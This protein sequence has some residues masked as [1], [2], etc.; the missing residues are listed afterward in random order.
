MIKSTRFAFVCAF[1]SFLLLFVSCPNTV[2]VHEE[3]Q[4]SQNQ[5]GTLVVT[6]G[7]SAARALNVSEI[8]KA[9]VSVS[10]TGITSPLLKT[11]VAISA[12]TAGEIKIEN[13]PV[14]KNRVVTVEAKTTINS[15]LQKMAGVT[16]TAVTDISKG[17]NEV[18]VNWANTKVGNVYA[19]LL[20]LGVDL[21]SIETE[22]VES[23]L[24]EN[25]HAS[26][27][28][29]AQIAS[30]I[31]AGT[32]SAS[33]KESYKIAPGSFTFTSDVSSDKISFQICDPSSQKLT[34]V[35]SG[36]NTIENI[37]PGN[38][39]VFGIVNGTSVVYASSVEILSGE[40][41]VF[42]DSIKFKTPA[43]RLED[44]DGNEIS[45]FINGTTKVYLKARTLDGEAEPD[46]VVIYYTTDGSAPTTSSTKYTSSGIS[47]S[48]GT[49][50]KAIAV[51]DGLLDSEVSE[52]TF[53]KPSLGNTHPSSGSYSP[54]D[55]NGA[56]D[57]Y[58]WSSGNWA[59]GANASGSETT[60][61]LYSANATKILLE[62]YN[63]PYGQ[64]AMYD[65]WMEKDA[66]NVWRAKL[67]GDLNGAIYAFRVWGPNWTYSSD[68][69]R[70]GSSEGFVSD[71]DS[72]GN[73]FNPNKVVYDPYARE[74]THDP[75][76]A[77][78]IASY[79]TT[80]SSYALASPEYQIL[81]TG[82]TSLLH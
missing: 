71:C 24:P 11:N 25:T 16:M 79:K 23:Y 82:A 4:S 18:T 47:V 44:A 3:N 65:Y 53:A 61:A 49:S 67:S 48:S 6:T 1:V 27:I 22:S 56:S 72:S 66:D 69:T 70:G 9:D 35:T 32:A 7:N 34:S 60:F 33:Q 15:V 54:V 62:I 59:L 76:N 20:K 64:E 28:N 77:S 2:T 63:A 75:S 80:N 13:I 52:W 30:D 46:G 58:G 73:R 41:S 36:S 68:W 51:C 31:K 29:A 17:E 43:P 39:K 26:L 5:F 74:M 8:E 40:T 81:S 12:G 19:E 14:G 42:P 37:A 21:S 50:V 57:G 38:W 45:E 55:M 78:A 10:G